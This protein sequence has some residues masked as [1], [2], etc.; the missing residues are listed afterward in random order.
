MKSTFRYIPTKLSMLWSSKLRN[1]A[2]VILIPLI[3]NA[4]VSGPLSF[5]TTASPNLLL[6]LGGSDPTYLQALIDF[7]GPDGLG[8]DGPLT[9]LGFDLT[10]LHAQYQAYITGG[11][12]PALF[13]TT[14]P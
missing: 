7:R 13:Q 4:P 12:L 6:P 14:L 10:W 11:G 1:A 5:P 9:R 8:K 2:V 3:I